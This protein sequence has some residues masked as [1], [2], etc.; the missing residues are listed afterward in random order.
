MTLSI[1]IACRRSPGRLTG[2]T[3]PIAN[4]IVDPPG[5]LSLWDQD[6]RTLRFLRELAG[7][8]TI[9][10]TPRWGDYAIEYA[11][12][13]A[14]AFDGVVAVADEILGEVERDPVP[15]SERD[16][17]LAWRTVDERAQ[18]A[19]TEYDHAMRIKQRARETPRDASRPLE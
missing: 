3:C 8:V 18:A 9:E 14:Q 17:A 13:I 15:I 4:V 5:E 19:L 11:A 6:A 12:L 10:T 16:L 2:A 7:V 1:V